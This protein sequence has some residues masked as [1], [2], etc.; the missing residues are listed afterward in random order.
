MIKMMT[1]MISM[2][3]MY[4]YLLIQWL[5]NVF[6]HCPSQGR[7]D[8]PT[9]VCRLHWQMTNCGGKINIKI[10]KMRMTEVKTLIIMFDVDDDVV[11]DDGGNDGRL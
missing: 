2:M 11:C 3:M 8:W 6:I 1:M 9:R 10:N 7:E 4:P 5:N